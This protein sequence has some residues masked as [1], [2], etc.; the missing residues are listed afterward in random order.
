MILFMIMNMLMTSIFIF[1]NHPMS[2]GLIL[3]IQ[4][5]LISLMSGLMSYTF[6]FSYIVFLVMLGGMLVLFIYMTSLASNEMFQ[7]S[8]KI[9]FFM[10]MM[11]ALLSMLL[12]MFPDNQMFSMLNKNSN[13]TEISNPMLFL[14]NENLIT[15]NKIYN[16]PNNMITIL[17]INYLLITLIAV[18]K[19]TSINTG[20]LRQKF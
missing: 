15:L 3:L 6:W 2:M 10:L 12:M 17:L 5:I 14:N 13:I 9:M 20:P 4:T 19:I 16:S 8:S 7:F 18:V 1:M 11:L